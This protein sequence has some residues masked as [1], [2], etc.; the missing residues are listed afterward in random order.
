MGQAYLFSLL[1]HCYRVSRQLLE[2]ND[3]VNAFLSPFYQQAQQIMD[4]LA[5]LGASSSP[6]QLKDIQLIQDR[7]MAIEAHKHNGVFVPNDWNGETETIPEGQAELNFLLEKAHDEVYH[8][9]CYKVAEEKIQETE[10]VADKMSTQIESWKEKTKG[11]AHEAQA[12]TADFQKYL[13]SVANEFKSRAVEMTQ[14]AK[15]H[16]GYAVSRGYKTLNDYLSTSLAVREML[17]PKLADTQFELS[18]IRDGL[19]KMRNEILL[20]SLSEKNPTLKKEYQQRLSKFRERL[21]SV[22]SHKQDGRFV[23]DDGSFAPQGQ[24]LLTGIMEECYAMCYEM[25]G[26]L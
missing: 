17:D 15:A 23:G 4:D 8:L 11:A 25:E 14:Q 12:S 1:F 22:E 9:L 13:M 21:V 7:L 16:I 2:A 26:Q 24:A 5:K 6:V 18:N 20:W 19:K 10:S 3:P